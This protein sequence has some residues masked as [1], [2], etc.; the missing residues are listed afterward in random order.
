MDNLEIQ[1]ARDYHD[2]TRHPGGVL[3]NPY[4]RYGP[5]QRPELFKL[6]KG[7]PPIPLP[8]EAAPP[9]SPGVGALGAIAGEAG[10]EGEQGKVDFRVLARLLHYSA[11]VTKYLHY[12]PPWGR[13]PFRAAACTGAL[14]HIE[15]YL[16]CGDLPGLAA[17]VYHYDPQASALRRLRQG[18][19]RQALLAASA[20]EPGLARAPAALAL[21]D[22]FKRNAVKYQA[23]E[24]RHAFWDSG[25][26]LANTL[27]VSDAL[28]LPSRV[29]LGFLDE[30]VG[31]LLGLHPE[32]E[33]PL[34]VVPLGSDAEANIPDATPLAPLELEIEPYARYLPDFPA[35]RAMHQAS[36]LP[37]AHAVSGWRAHTAQFEFPEPA[38]PLIE[39]RP[40]APGELPTD[41]IESVIERRGSTRKFSRAP[42][43]FEQLSTMLETSVRGLNADFTGDSD[44]RLTTAYLIA[45]V[46]DGLAPGAYAYHPDHGGLELLKSGDFRDAAGYLALN[47]DL[48]AD[49]SAAVFFLADLEAVLA[50]WGNRGYRAAQLDASVAAGRIYLAAYS[51]GFGATG[52]TFFDDAVIE[53]FSPHARGQ[54]VMFLIALGKKATQI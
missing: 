35:I 26:I 16:V 53:F 19:Y 29:V 23:R 34:A 47:Q 3:L 49:A 24:Y 40:L 4:H 42:I 15:L 41:P 36:S 51:L 20:G 1:I 46:V 52:L 43:R 18:D 28:G 17:G 11:G 30:A 48:G 45:N 44:T 6:Y 14:Y 38:G 12:P 22:V 21:T 39:L 8:L 7:L 9:G 50:R 54:S 37:D 27:A 13:M 10:S 25:V 31:Q 33:L 5:H 32:E 2:G